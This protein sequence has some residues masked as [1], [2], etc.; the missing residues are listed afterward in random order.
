MLERVCHNCGK[1]LNG[2]LYPYVCPYCN[3]HR[4]GENGE[5]A[6]TP[7]MMELARKVVGIQEEPP[8]RQRKSRERGGFTDEEILALGLYPDDE[9][10][11]MSLIS[12]ILG[13]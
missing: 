12:R 3:Y 7:E 6:P 1:V 10:Y 9:K 5:Y 13:K 8:I 2:D 4:Y 11:K